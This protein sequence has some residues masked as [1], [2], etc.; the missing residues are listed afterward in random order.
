MNDV[1]FVILKIVV[2]IATALISAAIIPLLHQKLVDGKYQQLLDIVE[3]AVRAAEQ[4]L[5]DE[6]GSFKKDAVVK[7][8]T[9]WMVDNG[10]V[11]TEAQLD[12]II[13][14]VVF[15]MKREVM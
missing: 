13:E 11:I 1:T 10:V 2:S 5:K 4:T 6:Y 7:F 3:I 14:A 12:Q 15:N 8:V 9:D